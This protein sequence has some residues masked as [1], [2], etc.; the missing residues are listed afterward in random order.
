[1]TT[2][3]VT[4]GSDH[5]AKVSRASPLAALSELI[6]NSLDADAKHV[7]VSFLENQLG[8]VAELLVADDGRG[9]AHDDAEARFA[10]LGGSWKRRAGMSDAGRYLHGSEGKGRFKALSLGRVVTWNVIY[11]DLVDLK[12]YALQLRADAS[13]KIEVTTPE[14]A[15]ANARSGVT[16]RIEEVGRPK[17]LFVSDEAINE[18]SETFATYLADYR[19]VIVEVDG[20]RLDPAPFIVGRTL[21]SLPPATVDGVTYEANLDLIEWVEQD[22]RTLFLANER[23]APLFKANRKFHVGGACFTAYLRSAYISLLQDQDALDLA[24]LN[25][26]VAQWLNDSQ[27]VIRE[28]FDRKA[29]DASESVIQDW[30]Q[31]Q[32]YPFKEEPKTLVQVA[33]RQIFN[34]VA[35]HVAKHVAEYTSGTRQSQ[36]LH[37][38]LLKTAI[39]KS[40]DELQRILSEVIS[41]PK[42]EQARLADLLKD[43]SLTSVINASA[44]VTDRLKLIM[45]LQTLIYEADYKEK[46]KERTQLHRIIAKNA[47]LFGEEWSISVDD[48]SLT[49]AL[50]AHRKILGD[51]VCIDE[52]VKHV[53]KTRGIIDLMLSR[54]IRRYGSKNPSHL[55][56]ELKAPKVTITQKEVTQIQGYARSVSEDN[57]F[58]KTNA[59]W[60]FWILST[61]IDDNVRFTI[62]HA[63]GVLVNRPNL[64][65]RVK[66]WSEV[67]EENRSRMQFYKELIEF[68]ASEDVALSHLS[69][70]Y[71]DLLTGVIE[72]DDADEI[73]AY[74]DGVS[75]GLAG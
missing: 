49:Q 37:L 6:W 51:H 69:E 22:R 56:V 7:K 59:E 53:S 5:L 34:I 3:T 41:L 24:E 58:D 63:N 18:L 66:L 44:V 73:P 71:A 39:E 61:N 31:Q 42:R 35:T 62:E 2:F 50:R 68:D 14:T 30:K 13:N 1:M 67:L 19:D 43:V 54:T 20:I 15:E 36:A 60:D 11:S 52:P 38:S 70:R 45:G 65:I 27:E 16:V 12:R 40:P 75:D 4:A 32:V 26:A 8:S 72:M 23:G 10:Q 28:H 57:R 25:G 46:L 48:R 21:I 74:E 47:W 55:V 9:L 64:K 33:E 29:A 17:S